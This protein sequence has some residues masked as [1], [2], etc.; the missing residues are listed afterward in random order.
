MKLMPSLENLY[1]DL[2]NQQKADMNQLEAARSIIMTNDPAPGNSTAG[3][4]WFSLITKYID[5]LLEI[6]KSIGEN[7]S[8]KL[9]EDVQSKKGQ[10]A[11]NCVILGIVVILT[12]LMIMAVIKMTNTIMKYAAKLEFTTQTLKEEQKRTDAVLSAMFPLS[13]AETL[14]KGEKVNSEYYDN[15]TVFFSDIVNFT[16]ICSVISPMEV[17]TML[18]AVYR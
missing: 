4:Q 8:E 5:I 16:N 14:K 2:V 10:L 11:I 17:T 6:Q 7:V 3:S 18:N 1:K 12:P 15:V 9:K 13:V